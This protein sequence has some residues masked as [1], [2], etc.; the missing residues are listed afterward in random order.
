MLKDFLILF[1]SV[2]ITV[3]LYSVFEKKWPE[4]DRHNK[5][6]VGIVAIGL[7]TAS[8]NSFLSVFF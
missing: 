8:I 5:P 2:G 4:Y 1:F 3:Y 7:V 6:Y